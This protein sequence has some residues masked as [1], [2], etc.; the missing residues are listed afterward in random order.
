MS[1]NRLLKKSMTTIPESAVVL[2]T[3]SRSFEKVQKSISYKVL[4]MSIKVVTDLRTL[5]KLARELAI[6][7]KSG[8]NVRIQQA[9]QKHDDYKECILTSDEVTTGL[10]HGEMC[11]TLINK[12]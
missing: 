8:D 7:E 2:H 1:D 3:T 5:I 6:A 9:K 11:G 10:T 4:I 12:E